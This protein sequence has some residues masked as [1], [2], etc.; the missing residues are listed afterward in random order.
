M[1]IKQTLNWATEKLKNRKISSA[2][3][4]AEVLLCYTINVSKVSKEWIY[5]H[6]AYR[7]PSTV[8]SHYKNLIERRARYEPVAYITGK[9]EFYDL[10]FYVTKDVLIPR[11]ETEILVEQVIKN[12][13]HWSLVTKPLTIVDVGTGSGCIAVTLALY[14]QLQYSKHLKKINVPK[15]CDRLK[16]VQRNYLF[17]RI[18][19]IDISPKA[20]HIAKINAKKHNVQNKITFLQGDLLKPL[21]AKYYLPAG[22]AGVLCANIIVANLPYISDKE[23]K[24][25]PN[26]IK[27]YEPRI[28]LKG[29]K[30]GLEFYEKLLSQ[31]RKHLNK[32]GKIFLEISP[33]QTNL[34]K[35]IAKKY[36]PK[37]KIEIIKDYSGLDRVVSIAP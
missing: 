30:E 35:K 13:N 1:T 3:L 12:T 17:S 4:D 21:S 2:Y 15:K 26:D 32:N 9:K 24:K 8:Y 20:L 27:K 29:G 19:A 36:F 22:K 23:M 28:S 14:L 31:A 7:L 10:L 33:K 6:P 34:I 18:Y 25:L 37:Y 16:L 5:T 11:P